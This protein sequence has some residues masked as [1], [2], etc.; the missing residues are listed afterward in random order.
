M[1]ANDPGLKRAQTRFTAALVRLRQGEQAVNGHV[2]VPFS[3]PRTQAAFLAGEVELD[4]GWDVAWLSS[5]V[6]PRF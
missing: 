3:W 6:L 2:K 4:L 5:P 1:D